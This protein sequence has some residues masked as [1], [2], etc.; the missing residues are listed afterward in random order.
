MPKTNNSNYLNSKLNYICQLYTVNGGETTLLKEMSVKAQNLQNFNIA[1]GKFSSL[2]SRLA[3]L[4]DG[5][6]VQYLL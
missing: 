4:E 1:M 6:S 5:Q 2:D 3:A